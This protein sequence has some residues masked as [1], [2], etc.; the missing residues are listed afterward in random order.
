M[1]KDG[2]D[3]AAEV[4]GLLAEELTLRIMAEYTNESRRD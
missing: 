4:V 2:K 3:L 1:G